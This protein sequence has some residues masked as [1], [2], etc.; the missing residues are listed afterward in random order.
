MHGRLDRKSQLM[1]SRCHWMHPLCF[2][3]LEASSSPVDSSTP[4]EAAAER[5]RESDGFGSSDEQE[6]SAEAL[7]GGRAQPKGERL[8]G[9]RDGDCRSGDS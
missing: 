4:G 8:G 5:S 6:G 9:R 1:A 3:N 2:I 7:R